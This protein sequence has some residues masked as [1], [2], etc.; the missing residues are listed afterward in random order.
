MTDSL[1]LISIDTKDDPDYE[2][3]ETSTEDSPPAK[4]KKQEL[5]DERVVG[6]IHSLRCVIHLI[7]AVLLELK[8]NP[9]HYKISASMIAKRRTAFRESINFDGK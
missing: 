3:K 6:V 5:I 7:V 4:V 9:R 8:L 2:F 1:S